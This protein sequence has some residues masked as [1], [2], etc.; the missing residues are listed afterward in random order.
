MKNLGPVKH[1]L[2]IEINRNWD[3]HEISLTQTEYAT[4]LLKRFGMENCAPKPTPMEDG[5]R[6]DVEVAGEP[7]SED[8]K[9]RYQQA[10]GSLLYL[11]LG[12]RPDISLAVG[13]LSRFT[14]KPHELHEKALNRVFH[15][16]RG[17]LDVGITYSRS[18]STPSSLPIPTGFADA[19]FA[20]L[21]VKEGRRSISGY[22]FYLAGGPI[23][24]SS[25][26][27]S[28]VAMSSME[29][30]YIGQFNAA[31]E[32]VWIR[33]FLEELGYRDLIK[34]PLVIKADNNGAQS[35]ARDPTIHSRAKHLNIAYH[36]QRQQVERKILQFHYIPSKENGAD[37]LTKPLA[38]QLFKTFKDLIQ[39]KE[40]SAPIEP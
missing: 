8:D 25:K 40:I 10:V 22:I 30:E 7:L 20:H 11:L 12:T 19:S 6:L 4:G 36:W 18:A 14:A 21:V 35:L 38:A 37:G 29:A 5:I 31:R 32:G 26:R 1:Y 28:T 34:D 23:S 33:T 39:V 17:T 15:Y 9:N 3:K 2:G 27:Q 24:W 16:L 13:I